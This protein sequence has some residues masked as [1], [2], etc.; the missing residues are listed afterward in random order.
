MP[1]IRLNKSQV[2]RVK[3]VSNDIADQVQSFI[4]DHSTVSVERTVLRFFGVD[5][6]DKEGTPLSNIVIDLLQEC[7]KL[8]N[9]ISYPFAHAMLSCGKDAQATA[10]LIASGK[11]KFNDL[12]K[13]PSEKI[14]DVFINTFF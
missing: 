12:K 8:R 1:N 9:G 10:R 4:S 6:V 14:K 7:G 2:A 13:I 3:K 5:G 11:L